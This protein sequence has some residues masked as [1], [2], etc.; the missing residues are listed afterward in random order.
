[1]TATQTMAT[2][3]MTIPQAADFLS[4]S[5]GLVYQLLRRGELPSVKIGR[6]RRIPRNAV[7]RYAAK[8]L[9][10]KG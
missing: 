2:G 4:I 8:R 1:M 6:L 3:L 9:Q 7:V 10:N 5:R